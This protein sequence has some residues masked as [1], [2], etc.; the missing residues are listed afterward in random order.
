MIVASGAKFVTYD[1]GGGR[2]AGSWD[3]T[4]AAGIEVLGVY[5]GADYYSYARA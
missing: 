4:N 2:E 3:Y 5:F 1:V